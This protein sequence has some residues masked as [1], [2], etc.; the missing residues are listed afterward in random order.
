MHTRRV[1]RYTQNTTSVAPIHTDCSKRKYKESELQEQKKDDRYKEGQPHS[2]KA[3]DSS[4]NPHL[5]ACETA[6]S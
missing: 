2:H 5:D 6:L 4:K 1:I 3:L